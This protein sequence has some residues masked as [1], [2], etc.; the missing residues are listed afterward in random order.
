[1]AKWSIF[2]KDEK[3][4]VLIGLTVEQKG[5][6][7]NNEVTW[8]RVAIGLGGDLGVLRYPH[9]KTGRKRPPNLAGQ[10]P[11]TI[12]FWP[13]YDQGSRALCGHLAKRAV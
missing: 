13:S 11:R 3:F 10:I 6:F 1:M 7:W 12:S 2:V 5:V 9:P 4:V 8:G